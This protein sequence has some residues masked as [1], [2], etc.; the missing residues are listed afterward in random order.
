PYPQIISVDDH[1]LEPPDLWQ[2]WLPEAHRAAGPGVERQKGV[3]RPGRRR[4]YFDRTGD[5]EWADIWVYEG[6]GMPLLGGL[7]LAGTDR[8]EANNHPIL[9][10]RI[11]DGAYQQPARLADMDANHV[12]ASLCFP[13]FPASV[14]RRSSRRPTRSSRSP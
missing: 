4:P 7:A 2:R 12:E 9:Y 5:G 11:P 13:S 3:V 6:K 10:E 8:R 14:A 1:V